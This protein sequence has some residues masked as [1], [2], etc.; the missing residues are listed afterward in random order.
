MIRPDWDPMTGSIYDAL[1]DLV[2]RL[3]TDSNLRD[4]AQQ[5]VLDP[6]S[7]RWKV[8]R[9]GSAETRARRRAP[10]MTRCLP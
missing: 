9:A 5:F 7:T 4:K 1:D 2:D 3:K 6:V 8:R 10:S